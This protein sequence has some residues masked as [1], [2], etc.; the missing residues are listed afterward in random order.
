MDVITHP[1]GALPSSGPGIKIHITHML[2]M[3]SSKLI[4]VI[5]SCHPNDTKSLPLP[6]VQLLANLKI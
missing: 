5:N 4:K 2:D 1:Y 3:F 6:S